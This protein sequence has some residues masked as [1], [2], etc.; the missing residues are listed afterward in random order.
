M[1]VFAEDDPTLN[2][3]GVYDCVSDHLQLTLS[4]CCHLLVR[5]KG[6]KLAFIPEPGENGH[7]WRRGWA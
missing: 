2:H 6:E 7:G 1:R 5:V 3:T 4:S